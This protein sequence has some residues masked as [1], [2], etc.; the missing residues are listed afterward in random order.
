MNKLMVAT[1]LDKQDILYLGDKIVPGGNDYAVQQ[2]GIDCIAVSNWEDTAY[3]IEGI[4]KV[5]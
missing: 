1:G 3:A 2:M 5:V 4:V